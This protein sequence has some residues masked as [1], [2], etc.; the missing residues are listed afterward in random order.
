M[1]ARFVSPTWLVGTI[2]GKNARHV[3]TIS[4]ETGALVRVAPPGSED[5]T[6]RLV[7]LAAPDVRALVRGV[8]EILKLFLGNPKCVLPP[9]CLFTSIVL[10]SSHQCGRVRRN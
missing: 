7:E 2:L 10:F 6:D 9:C 8:E 1:K 5:E 4:A 3:K